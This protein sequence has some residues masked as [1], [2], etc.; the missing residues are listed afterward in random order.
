MATE[1][2]QRLW[3]HPFVN[4][5]K[6]FDVSKAEYQGDVV[7]ELDKIISKR[8]YKMYGSVSANNFLRIPHPKGAIKSL[9]LTGEFVYLQVREIGHRFFL[10]HLDFAVAQQNVLRFTLSNMY[11]EVKATSRA[12]LYPCRLGENWSVVCVHVPSI[13]AIFS[14][15]VAH[16]HSLK[17]IQLC[18][19]LL[20]RNVYTSDIRYAPD[21]LPREMKLDQL[22]GFENRYSWVDVPGAASENY[23]PPSANAGASGDDLNLPSLDLSVSK[24]LFDLGNM[25]AISKR[26]ILTESKA[27]GYS[28]S[29]IPDDALTSGQIPDP[30]LEVSHLVGVN[31]KSR[32]VG[33]TMLP[34]R[35]A[36]WVQPGGAKGAAKSA[37]D[38]T[39]AEES[40]TLGGSSS[41][42]SK[43]KLLYSSSMAL[44]LLD[45]ETKQEKCFFGHSRPIEL[46]VVSDD[47][48]WCMSSQGANADAPPLFR[49]WQVGANGVRCLSVLSCPSLTSIKAFQFDSLAKFVV[50]VGADVQ[51]RQQLMI[52][53]ISRVHHGGN[54]TIMARQTSADWDIECI[55]FSPYEAMRLMSCGRENIRYWRV[56]EGHLPGCNVTLN[57][58]ARG[59]QFTDLDFECNKSGKPNFLGEELGQLHRIFVS[60]SRGEVVQL[61]YKDKSVQ[62]VYQLHHQAITSLCANEGFV[63]T[64]SADNYIRVWPLD[65][66]SFYLHAKHDS[67]VCGVDVTIDGLR[68]AC[69]TAS[70]AVGMLD[71]KSHA[72][73]ELVRSH[74][75][76]ISD[77]SLSIS[78]EELVTICQD[79]TVKIW[80]LATMKQTYE[81]AV[82]DDVPTVCEFHPGNKHL[83]AVGFESGALR[84][85][86]V[87]GPRVR[88]EFQHHVFA[89][90]SIAFLPNPARPGCTTALL[91]SCDAKGSLVFYDEVFDFQIVRCPEQSLYLEPPERCPAVV[92]A[93]TG[94]LILQYQ[95]PRCIG[96]LSFPALEPRKK[97][98]LSGNMA[99]RT[100]NFSF[101]A[102][103]ILVGSTD[104][105]L[106]IYH[107]LSTE[108]VLELSFL[109][110]PFCALAMT[111]FNIKDPFKAHAL[112][113]TVT[114]DTLVKV[115]ELFQREGDPSQVS[116]SSGGVLEASALH[117]LGEQCFI[118][119]ATAPHKVLMSPHALITVSSSEVVNW[120]VFGEYFEYLFSKVLEG[121]STKAAPS[122]KPATPK[123]APSP[124]PAASPKREASPRPSPK[125]APEPTTA[126]EPPKTRPPAWSLAGV[127][128]CAVGASPHAFAW[129]SAHSILCHTVGQVVQIDQMKSGTDSQEMTAALLR[130]IPGDEAVALDLDPEGELLAVISCSA[131]RHPQSDKARQAWLNLWRV[132]DFTKRG[133]MEL[134]EDYSKFRRGLFDSWLTEEDPNERGWPE[135]RFLQCGKRLASLMPTGIGAGRVDLWEA[136]G[137]TAVCSAVISFRPLSLLI[138]AGE[139]EFLTLCTNAVIFWRHCKGLDGD[140]LEF[141]PADVPERFVLG[142]ARFSAA[143]VIHMDDG[144]HLIVAGT[145]HGYAWIFSFEENQLLSEVRIKEG[146]PVDSMAFASW[147]LLLCGLGSCLHSIQLTCDSQGRFGVDPAGERPQPVSL[148]GHIRALRFDSRRGGGVASTSANSLWYFQL[149]QGFGMRF[150]LQSFH[151]SPC[152]MLRSNAD[153][154]SGEGPPVLATCADDGTVRIW[155]HDVRPQ[156]VAQFTGGASC[157]GIAFLD[158]SLILCSFFDGHVRAFDLQSLSA[159]AKIEVSPNSAIVPLMTLEAISTQSA[160]VGGADGS[161]TEIQIR[162]AARTSEALYVVDEARRVVLQ[163]PS[164]PNEGAVCGIHANRQ[165]SSKRFLVAF[166]NLELRIWDCPGQVSQRPTHTRTWVWPETHPSVQQEALR[167]R[168]GTKWCLDLLANPPLVA[169]FVLAAN[170]DDARGGGLVVC[171]APPAPCCYVF[172]CDAG[173]VINRIAFDP[174]TPRIL[175]MRP[176]TRPAEDGDPPQGYIVSAAFAGGVARLMLYDCGRAGWLEES[177]LSTPAGVGES[178]TPDI[179]VLQRNSEETTV[180]VS[181]DAT[182]SCW[183]TVN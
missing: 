79:G 181:T 126:P 29:A 154:S 64:G 131:S 47:G 44:V 138:I 77:A 88:Y 16:A 12:I 176:L 137:C 80:S 35:F 69:S 107:V 145:N 60:S 49:I 173:G 161:I 20:V 15:M 100:F 34:K 113:I 151:S 162:F 59:T 171:T 128:G 66:Q 114:S 157:S 46:L 82:E 68:V 83:V 41:G 111:S 105:K 6:E 122:P 146:C 178:G 127:T 153:F 116:L 115:T 87:D 2:G 91:V 43:S 42:S 149:N 158:R 23:R 136:E 10:I 95:D 170:T 179:T 18:S 152:R 180:V 129:S 123:T 39:I 65:F 81:F 62:A 182:L 141:Q 165:V 84:I 3:Q 118:A 31:R 40:S 99:I 37:D 97:I 86:D 48:R 54:A 108:P 150:R 102:E 144:K 125:S 94:K 38:S 96:L 119:H 175:R 78:F 9:G 177:F 57:A 63:V 75:S 121:E 27:S 120:A 72:Y 106:R 159:I 50:L 85:F 70:G 71:M 56:K 67:E 132:S 166:S 124:K 22:P 112:L 117:H 61:L 134:P 169:T 7:E 92:V 133:V 33:D 74:S 21:D 4:V 11:N 8:I 140:K 174:A 163:S 155:S 103:Y 52:W 17:S 51:R 30:L 130:K 164:Y 109:G 101:D 135:V 168:T 143:S 110:G 147:P 32:A 28:T 58:L 139:E 104:S 160:I 55:K 148:D 73:S 93:S 25:S 142:K 76:P 98:R 14:R 167:D 90:R 26:P 1:K 24:P 5:F 156:A 172:D 53:D 89:I 13:L 45:P 19:C 183:T 36:V